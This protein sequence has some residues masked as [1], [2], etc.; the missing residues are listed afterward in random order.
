M[1]KSSHKW[2][3]YL[4]GL[5]VLVL[6]GLK[7]WEETRWAPVTESP[8]FSSEWATLKDA[9]WQPD[10]YNDGDSFKLAHAGGVQEFRLYFVDCPEKRLH[11]FNE[12]RLRDQ[13]KDFG[14]RSIKEMVEIGERGRDFTQKLLTSRPFEVFTRWEPV[15]KSRRRYVMIRVTEE[16]GTT[17][18]LSE[19]LV[20]E[21]LAR[22]H[23]KGV[24]LPD[25]TKEKAFEKHLREVEKDA[26]ANRRGAWGL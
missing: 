11:D 20:R 16:D 17:R 26:K 21:G 8:E 1:K 13:G 10:G 7:V 23:T 3:S 9:R 4:W 5:L 12:D 14:G 6:M 25:G 22:I 15:F 19:I 2:N 18:Y 24:D